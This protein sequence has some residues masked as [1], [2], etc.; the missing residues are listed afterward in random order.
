MRAALQD[1]GLA[2][3][4]VDY[5]N[6]HGTGTLQND[7]AESRALH[8][9]FGSGLAVSSTKGLTGHTLGACGALEAAFAV[10]SIVHGQLPGSAGA[11]PLDPTLPI[12]V[13]TESLQRPVRHAMSNAL[14]FGGNN[15]SLLLAST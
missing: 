1:A 5:L 15:I 6:A 3:E 9:V 13:L 11:L 12:D 4:E 7:A 10:L 8:E 2:P 14:A